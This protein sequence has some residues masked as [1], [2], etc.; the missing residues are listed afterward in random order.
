MVEPK[1]EAGPV[2]GIGL[3]W[4]ATQQGKETDAWASK[5]TSSFVVAP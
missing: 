2:G 4:R 3:G 5:P 1:P